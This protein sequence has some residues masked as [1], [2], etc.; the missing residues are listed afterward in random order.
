MANVKSNWHEYF[1]S[2][3]LLLVGFFAQQTYSTIKNDHEVLA[4]HET[5]I[6]VLEKT[7][8][9]TSKIFRLPTDAVLEYGKKKDEL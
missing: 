2:G 9:R 5:R 1:N 6:T 4:N 8:G 7:Q 3:L